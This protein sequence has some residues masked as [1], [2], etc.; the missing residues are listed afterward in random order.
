MPPL[1]LAH[2]HR[3]PFRTRVL[4]ARKWNLELVEAEPV[5]EQADLTRRAC[6]EVDRCRRHLRRRHR[7]VTLVSHPRATTISCGRRARPRKRPRLLQTDQAGALA[8]RIFEFSA[9]R[10]SLQADGKLHCPGDVFPSMSHSR[11]TW[12]AR[13]SSQGGV[14][15]V[16]RN[17][18]TSPS[19]LEAGDRQADP[20]DA[21]RPWA[22]NGASA[23]DIDG[24]PRGRP[25]PQMPPCP[26][27]HRVPVR[28]ATD[29]G[30]RHRPL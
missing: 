15:H 4:A 22:K 28:I 24:D 25:F 14:F 30:R 3:T 16:R 23:G 29:A 10:L 21:P 6:H 12:R 5:I 26:A 9:F 17:Y 7:Q 1:A 27:R 18:M 11:F 8:I 19:G 2:R 13:G 20:V